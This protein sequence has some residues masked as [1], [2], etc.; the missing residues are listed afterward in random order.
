LDK[1]QVL[2]LHDDIEK[3]LVLETSETNLDFWTVCLMLVTAMLL[4][5]SN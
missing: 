4:L 3:Y 2:E 5:T 1:P